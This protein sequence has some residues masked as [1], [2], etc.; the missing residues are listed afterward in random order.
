MVEPSIP[1]RMISYASL[2][3]SDT[4]LDVGAGMGFLA[5]LMAHKCRTLLAVEADEALANILREEVSGFDNVRVI[6]GSIFKVNIPTFDKIVS[7]PPYNISSRLLLWLFDRSFKRAV[8]V[9]QKEFAERLSAAVGSEDYSWL[10]V[11]TCCHAEVELLDHVPKSSFYPQPE[12]DSVITR[13]IPG[14]KQFREGGDGPEFKR[15]VQ[16]LFTERNRKVGKAVLSYLRGVRGLTRTDA[17][18]ATEY[19]PYTD[20]RVRELAPEDFLVLANALSR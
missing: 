18:K 4:V 20:R 2:K 3:K 14:E 16:M 9:L 19:L 5:R 10:T 15:L 17:V 8:L 1:E 6:E 11:F 13:L 12:V 7:T